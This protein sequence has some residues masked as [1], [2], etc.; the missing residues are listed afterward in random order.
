MSKLFLLLILASRSVLGDEVDWRMIPNA[1][2]EGK[3]WVDAGNMKYD[4]STVTVSLNAERKDGVGFY[5]VSINC[6]NSTFRTIGGELQDKN[7][8]VISTQTPDEKPV[9]APSGTLQG[10]VHRFVCD[11][12]PA[13]RK[14]FQ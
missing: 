4:G 5:L 12:R 6:A 13:W 11:L 3:I 8:K 10:N 2:P 9:P 14:L 1:T 7:G